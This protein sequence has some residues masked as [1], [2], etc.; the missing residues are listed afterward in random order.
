MSPRFAVYWDVPLRWLAA[1]Q[2]LQLGPRF[3]RLKKPIMLFALV[4]VLGA[5]DLFQ[6]WRYFAH[7]GIYDPVSFQLL[8]AAKLIK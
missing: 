1:S 5:I 3:P 8:H 2:L 4:L 6:Y 7:G